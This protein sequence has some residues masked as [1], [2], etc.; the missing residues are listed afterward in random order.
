MLG[1]GARGLHHFTEFVGSEMDITINWL[2]TADRL[3]DEDPVVT[4]RMD[5]QLPGCLADELC[6]KIDDFR[7]AWDEDGLSVEE[8][9][10]FGPVVHFR[11]S[12]IKGWDYLRKV[13]QDRRSR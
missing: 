11:N 10:D 9:E 6:E 7:R 3:I 2:G 13:I 5:T 12:F 1:G 8:Y 4:W